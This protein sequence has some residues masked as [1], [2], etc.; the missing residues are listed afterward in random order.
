MEICSNLKNI[1][2]QT[3]VEINSKER[4]IKD[5]SFLNE[6][7]KFSIEIEDLYKKAKEK[8]QMNSAFEEKFESTKFN[9]NL[10][11]SSSERRDSV[12]KKYLK[13]CNENMTEINDII[14]KVF[15]DNPQSIKDNLIFE[16]NI[17][18]N[19]INNITHNSSNNVN[20]N[21]NLNLNT[22]NNVSNIQHK[23]KP[24]NFHKLTKLMSRKKI[25]KKQFYNFMKNNEEDLN[26]S[27]QSLMSEGVIIK[28]PFK[29]Y[30]VN[31]PKD[32][33]NNLRI[34]TDGDF[35][36]SDDN[37]DFDF[38]SDNSELIDIIDEKSES[39][40]IGR[41]IKKK[42]NFVK[43]RSK[44]FLGIRINNNLLTDIDDSKIKIKKKNMIKMFND[45]SLSKVLLIFILR[46]TWIEVV[47]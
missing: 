10:I 18:T 14:K 46:L 29:L 11:K 36:D 22:I 44:S 38:D 28:M 26:D 35:I 32:D 17:T 5:F 15:I 45:M 24:N 34:L 41:K 13:M 12:Y 43:T 7:D 42:N 31:K 39:L 20:V 33:L 25:S 27:S 19:I 23:E 37:S 30:Q 47:Q 21:V 3:Q 9:I 2:D 8:E 1:I 40:I 16:Q 6:I 4:D